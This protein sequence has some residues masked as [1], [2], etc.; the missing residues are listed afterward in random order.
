MDFA[1]ST[2]I[3][4]HNAANCCFAT[5]GHSAEIVEVEELPSGDGGGPTANDRPRDLQIDQ[6]LEDLRDRLPAGF[7]TDRMEQP[8]AAEDASGPAVDL[9]HV[10]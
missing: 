3:V 9:N 1:V 10:V 8:T 5:C 2:A 4:V 7:T 6:I